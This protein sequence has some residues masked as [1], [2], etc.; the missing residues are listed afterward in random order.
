MW[1]GILDRG[2]HVGRVVLE[3]PVRGLHKYLSLSLT[4]LYKNYIFKNYIL[5]YASK[6]A[7][8]F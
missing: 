7:V 5:E 2:L 3:Y 1:T 4:H 8:V 6:R